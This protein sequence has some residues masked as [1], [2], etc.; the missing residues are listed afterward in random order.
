MNLKSKVKKI[1]EELEDHGFN[2]RVKVGP[3]KDCYIIS[4]TELKKAVLVGVAFGQIKCFSINV[5]K[6]SWAEAEGF[7]R[8]EMVEN[9]SSEIFKEI[10]INDI[11][12]YIMEK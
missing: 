6:W 8:D 10:H 5:K 1:I 7:T 11:I 12:K 3:D 9:F 2:V 4:S